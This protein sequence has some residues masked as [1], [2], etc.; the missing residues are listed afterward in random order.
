MFGADPAGSSRAWRPRG[1]RCLGAPRGPKAQG[2]AVMRRGGHSTTQ[3][4]EEEDEEEEEEDGM[5]GKWEVEEGEEGRAGR[6]GRGGQGTGAGRGAGG[7][8]PSGASGFRTIPIGFSMGYIARHWRNKSGA[9][10]GGRAPPHSDVQVD[11]QSG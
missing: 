6:E 1:P 5:G 11:M 7:R 2:P 4:K 10:R 8:W 9:H 3:G